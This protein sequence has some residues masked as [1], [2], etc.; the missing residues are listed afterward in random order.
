M[1]SFTSI[2]AN[3]RTPGQHIEFDSSRA[4]SGLPPI[5][6]RV[7]LVGQKLAAGSADPLEVE[8]I[9]EASQAIALFGRGSMLARM[10][11]AYK[12]ADRYSELFAIAFDDGVGAV[13]ATGTVTITGVATASGTASLVIAGTRVSA[14]VAKDAVAITVAAALAA[15]VN[16]LPDLPVTAAV[17]AAPND[18][19]ITLT[20]RNKGTIGN[21]I[22]LRKRV[23]AGAH[24]PRGM[25]AA[26]VQMAGGAGDPDPATIWPVLGDTAYR[27]IVFGLLDDA[28]VGGIVAELD[29]RWGA[30]RMLESVGYAA[31][32]GTQGQL[33]A[34]GADLNSELLSVL[35]IGD[36]PTWAP[37]AA[38]IYAAVCGYYSAIDPA[39]PLHTLTLTGLAPPRESLAFTRAERESLLRDGIATYTVDRDG[40]CRIERAITTYQ[41]D[42]FGIEDVAYLD[43]E[44]VTTLGYLRATLRA[45]VAQKF[46]RHKLADDD[47][48]YG[49]GQAVVTPKIIR[50]EIIA[51]ARE[52]EE[53]ALVE[54]LDQFTVD[55]LVERDAGDPNRVNALVPPDIV[56]QFRSFAAAIQFR[57]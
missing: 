16:A 23:F 3:I 39:R 24:M 6:N 25:D 26:I 1:I 55:I 57:L 45:R 28:N 42:S 4:V 21:D 43:L 49:A 36:S 46:P 7:L 22:D 12:A 53:A 27:T 52:W 47:T 29:D 9:V 38:A 2:P 5:A 20:A 50:A 30:E 32:S 35:G 54:N 48:R 56:N 34:F 18:H 19:V 8:P 17:G 13:A 31:I 37:E 41:T 14:A 51:L 40:T 11:A 33:A 15:A 44:N 10:A